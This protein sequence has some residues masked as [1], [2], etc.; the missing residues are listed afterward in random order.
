[1]IM[2]SIEDMILNVIERYDFEFHWK[3]MILNFI[4]KN[5]FELNRM[6]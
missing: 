5:D 2:N 4:G 6:I 1:M 3:K